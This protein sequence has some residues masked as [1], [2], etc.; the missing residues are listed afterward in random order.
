MRE[1]YEL[2]IWR[3]FERGTVSRALCLEESVSDV[4]CEDTLT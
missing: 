4:R 1:R 2:S 3:R